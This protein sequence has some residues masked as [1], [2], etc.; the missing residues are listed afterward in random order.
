MP[1]AQVQYKSE[2]RG[3]QLSMDQGP[4]P[5]GAALFCR[6]PQVQSDVVGLWERTSH[7]TL[8]E[9]TVCLVAAEA[10][11]PLWPPQVQ[12]RLRK[13]PATW[14]W[15]NTFQRNETAHWTGA[16]ALRENVTR[17]L[18][19]EESLLVHTPRTTPTNR[20]Q[21]GPPAGKGPLLSDE[22]VVRYR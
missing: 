16:R 9:R 18:I 19:S 5:G 20:A 6:V 12:I 14:S 22:M 21:V 10:E 2:R 3:T 8:G 4:A 13:K 15:R 17:L 11:P 1:T 7:K